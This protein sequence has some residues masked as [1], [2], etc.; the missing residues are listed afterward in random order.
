MPQFPKWNCGGNNYNIEQYD[1]NTFVFSAD[2]DGNAFAARQAVDSYRKYLVQNGFHQAGQYPNIEHLYKKV[3]G[4]VYHVDTEHCFEGDP[5]CLSIG[6]DN[7]EPLG[8]YDYVK[9]E[10]KKTAS[11][12]DLFGF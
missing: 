7:G 11:F 8:G 9:P 6:F 4:T 5:D 1:V 10:P 3:D 2:F 12:K